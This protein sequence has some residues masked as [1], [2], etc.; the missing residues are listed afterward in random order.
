[1][2]T[3]SRDWIVDS[4]ATCK[5]TG[6]KHKACAKCGDTLATE[7]I[8][9]RDHI[10]ENNKCKFCQ[11]L[12]PS[13]GLEYRLS[14]DNSYYYVFG[15]GTCTDTDIVI[16]STYENKPVKDIGDNAFSGCSQLT[17][18]AIPSGVT[19]IGSSAFSGCSGLTSITFENTNGWK[20]DGTTISSTDLAN[21]STAA[22]YLTST[23]DDAT[24][25]RSK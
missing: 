7:T 23:Y 15:I 16:P 1:M 13:E 22:N 17:S 24:W 5:V 3:R 8:P 12:E 25:I 21:T 11:E 4:E 18:I 2:H 19:S 9:L 6:S 14:Y 20:A 10:Y